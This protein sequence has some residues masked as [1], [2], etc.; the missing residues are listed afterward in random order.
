[1]ISLSRGDVKSTATPASLIRW[2]VTQLQKHERDQ[3]RFQA[4]RAEA[5]VGGGVA[6]Q[7]CVPKL[8]RNQGAS[9]TRALAFAA[10]L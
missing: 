7:R 10:T 4:Q 9:A 5:A 2:H 3:R 6:G 8:C 1:M